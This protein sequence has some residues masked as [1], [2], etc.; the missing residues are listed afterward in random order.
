MCRLST[1]ATLGQQHTADDQRTAKQLDGC[2][3]LVEQG[4]AIG[5]H[6]H[7]GTPSHDARLALAALQQPHRLPDAGG[8]VESLNL[9]EH[10]LTI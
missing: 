10:K 8:F 3:R 2:Q 1:L 6:H 5:L 9:F 4:Q 7:I